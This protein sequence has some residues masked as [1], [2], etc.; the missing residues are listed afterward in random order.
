MYRDL[1]YMDETP[2]YH[3][4][5]IIDQKLVFLLNLL[6]N[7]HLAGTEVVEAEST[8]LIGGAQGFMSTHRFFPSTPTL[9]SYIWFLA[10]TK[11][12]LNC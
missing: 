3:P 9:C 2:V 12:T 4:A 5:D 6:N 1:K 7:F 10:E 8:R 11:S